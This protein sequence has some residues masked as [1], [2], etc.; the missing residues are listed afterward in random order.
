MRE[1]EVQIAHKAA[2]N[3]RAEKERQERISAE[4]AALKAVDAAESSSKQ[5]SDAIVQDTLSDELEALMAQGSEPTAAAE[6]TSAKLAPAQGTVD[7]RIAALQQMT[8]R[9]RRM[10][11][12]QAELTEAMTALGAELAAERSGVP[13]P[14]TPTAEPGK[15]VHRRHKPSQESDPY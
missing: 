9:S 12:E 13:T 6:A 2:E 7:E 1:L 8:A 10:L 4:F 15:A 14:A 3:A 11:Q 5:L